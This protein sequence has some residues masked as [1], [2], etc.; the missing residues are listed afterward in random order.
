MV[1]ASEEET[2]EAASNALSAA[3]EETHTPSEG[4]ALSTLVV[5]E[6]LTASHEEVAASASGTAAED[7]LYL[8]YQLPL[9]L[10][11]AEKFR[12]KDGITYDLPFFGQRTYDGCYVDAKSVGDMLGI[13]EFRR[14]L[15]HPTSSYIPGVHYAYIPDNAFRGER[16]SLTPL[17]E[18]GWSSNPDPSMRWRRVL[19][20]LG[21]QRALFTSRN[22]AIADHYC[23]WA[24]RVLF[25]A[26]MGTEEQR[27]KL[28]AEVMGF[29]EES[30]R[31]F[32]KQ[33]MVGSQSMIY[34]IRVGTVGDLREGLQILTEDVP[35]DLDV[36]KWGKSCHYQERSAE[37]SK[38][39]GRVRGSQLSLTYLAHVDKQNL[40]A[41]ETSIKQ[42]L[43]GI[44]VHLN[45]GNKVDGHSELVALTPS[46]VK[47]ARQAFKATAQECGAEVQ[48][49]LGKLQHEV[50][51]E[52]V[53][54]QM[55][56]GQLAA[57]SGELEA[58]RAFNTQLLASK[59]ETH[60]VMAQLLVSKDEKQQ[61]MEKYIM[62]LERSAQ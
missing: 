23:S 40:F 47:A 2:P 4:E 52:R 24:S 35:D 13:A 51:V 17:N 11:D 43:C 60:Q 7:P 15:I 59:D 6:V 61:V 28:V 12:D 44:G 33:C 18:M 45:V 58:E 26:K 8:P 3:E 10:T 56:E 39:L 14:T 50:Q 41:A 38:G 21:T 19:T 5:Q 27:S 25:T 29:S 53:A 57:K 36:F 9:E 62:L 31:A 30:V 55:A 42:Y 34:L 48:S 46:H 16:D 49:E 20:W 22:N 32:H 37:H 1:Q 54:R